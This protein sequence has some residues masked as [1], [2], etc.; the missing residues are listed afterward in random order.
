VWRGTK[1]KFKKL[2]LEQKHESVAE[3]FFDLSAL[4]THVPTS[5]LHFLSRRKKR[6]KYNGSGD[7]TEK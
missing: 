2:S 5:P 7:D 3:K 1:E 4:L 6:N